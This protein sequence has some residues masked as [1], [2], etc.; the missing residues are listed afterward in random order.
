MN[1]LVTG[2]SG[3]LGRS[4]IPVLQSRHEHVFAVARTAT[5]APNHTIGDLTDPVAT[6]VL[7]KT[8]QPHVIVHLAGGNPPD[9]H[10]LYLSNV[11]TTVNLFQSLEQLG[12]R[13]YVISAGSAA[14]Y[15]ESNAARIDEDASLQPVT[16]YGRAKAAQ[17]ILSQALAQRAGIPLTL[18]RPFNIVS[19]GLPERSA[20]GNIRT[21]LTTQTGPERRVRCGRL[22][23]VRDFVSLNFVTEAIVRLV[24]SPAADRTLNI[25]SG[26]ALTLGEVVKAMADRLGATPVIEP[27]PELMALPAAGQAVG[28]PTALRELIGLSFDATADAIARIVLGET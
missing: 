12:R 20:L 6:Q 2:A 16:T 22:D 19:P 9:P 27:V 13:P 7:L 3:L 21:Q 24:E 26:V 8:T 17:T 23:V 10:D 5:G 15:G 25:C 18:V 28:D 14:E 4:L 11:V 1:I